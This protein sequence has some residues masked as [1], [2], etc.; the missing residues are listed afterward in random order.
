MPV[1]QRAN[2]PGPQMGYQKKRRRKTASE[3]KK[4]LQEKQIL[5]RLYGLQERQ[6]K[7]YVKE[8]LSRMGKVQDVANELVG[9]LEKRLDNVV[10]RLGFALSRA[11]ARQ[12]VSHG[13]FL[14]NSKPVNIPSFKI[15]IG[16]I[17]TIKESKKSKPVFKDLINSLKKKEIPSWLT[18][19]KEKF[20]G[21]IIGEPSLQEVNPP[22]EI[23]LIFEF[24]SR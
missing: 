15:K 17:V 13:I 4:S 23:S 20:E 6:F 1:T 19:D 7:K 12:L 2:L 16:D 8:T 9:S 22:A 3:Y 5:K 14:V 10:F 24:Y 11:H 21:K 18:L